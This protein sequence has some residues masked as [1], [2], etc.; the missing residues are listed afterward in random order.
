MIS[1]P[2][3]TAIHRTKPSVPAKLVTE[4]LIPKYGIKSILDWGCGRGA[5]VNHFNSCGI[6]SVGYDPNFA[7][8]MPTGSFDLVTCFY[9]LNV[10]FPNERMDCLRKAAEFVSP[11]GYMFVTV[12]S[13]KEIER[14]KTDHWYPHLDGWITSRKTFQYGFS[15][16][17]L[18]SIVNRLG[19]EKINAAILKKNL[20]AIL[21]KKE[22]FVKLMK[23][24]PTIGGV[25]SKRLNNMN[26]NTVRRRPR[27]MLYLLC[28]KCSNC[29]N[30]GLMKYP[31]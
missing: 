12:R 28:S 17:E 11:S 3:R 23:L 9:V 6:E 30:L 31:Q 15:Q 26:I 16:V 13:D 14:A 8:Q 19:F 2:S 20:T 22:N 29:S 7:P 27:Q 18:S 5:D 25:E 1:Y 24:K 21:A 10:L 4:Y